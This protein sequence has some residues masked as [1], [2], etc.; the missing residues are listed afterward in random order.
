VGKT[1]QELVDW[2]AWSC[3]R[4][5]SAPRAGEGG[6]DVA[7]GE[8]AG[9]PIEVTDFF[10]LYS[11]CVFGFIIGLSVRRIPEIV[12]DV[13]RLLFLRRRRLELPASVGNDAR[14]QA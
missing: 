1:A 7:D 9:E 14:R 12:I 13:V 2:L 4:D 10:K 11:F 5:A 3:D 6:E 8:A